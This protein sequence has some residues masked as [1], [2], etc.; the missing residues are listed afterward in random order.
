MAEYVRVEGLKELRIALKAIDDKLP[1]ELQRA[2]KEVAETVAERVRSSFLGRGGV[3]PKVASSV[4]A[5]ASQRGAHV[6]VGG[7]RWPYAM[8][9][10][11]GS[12]KFKQFP[13]PVGD[14]YSLYPT[15]YA[16]RDEITD[17]YADAID[18]VMDRHFR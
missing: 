13:P 14:G 10:T 2:S 17:R 18:D 3:A 5:L 12:N 4:K 6:R 1:K 11:F 8:G 7:D 9:S 15:I 16:M